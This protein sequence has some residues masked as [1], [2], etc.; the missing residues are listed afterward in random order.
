[1]RALSHDLR[2]LADKAPL[3]KK[4]MA[5]RRAVQDFFDGRGYLEV[6]TPYL[7]PTPGEEVHLRCFSTLLEKADGSPA[8]KRFLHTSPEFAMKRLVAA[9]GCPLYQLA[10]VWRNGER[11]ATHLPEFTMLEWYRPGADLN[12]L[13]DETEVL[14]KILLP[15]RVTYGADQL[16]LTVPFE[17]LTMQEAFARYVGADL[18]GT[19]NEATALAGQAGVPLREGED[20]EDLFFRLLLEKIE[21]H[22]G[23]KCPTFL[24]HWPFPQAALAKRDPRDRRTALRFELYAAGLELGNAFE[25]LT[26]ADEQRARFL[27]DRARR[28]TLYPDL[29]GKQD[30]PL[31][32]AFLGAIASM[33]PCAGIAMGFDRLVMLAT[34]APY[35]DETL[36]LG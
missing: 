5:M 21:P 23:R 28:M 9:L 25:E 10:R 17:R 18:L 27:E 13:M 22:I 33:P 35:I 30:W 6:E 11:S 32:E 31:D 7:V 1:M 16:D 20:W 8:E 19:I 24:T 29:A 34:G 4:R 14:L 3:V 2:S 12:S 36:W 15:S 26:D